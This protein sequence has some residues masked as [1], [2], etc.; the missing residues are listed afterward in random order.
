MKLFTLFTT[1]FLSLNVLVAATY[2]TGFEDASKT[3]YA[4][5][6]VTLSGM[7]WNMTEALIGSDANDFKNDTKSARLRGYST[8][9]ITMQ[10]N[11][12]GGIGEISFQYRRYGTD[13]QVTWRVEYSIDNGTTWTQAGVDFTAPASNDIQT[14]TAT[15]N[16]ASD[17]RI[18]II[19]ASGGASSNRRLNI[20]DIILTDYASCTA[21]SVPSFQANSIQ[22]ETR[23]F[24]LLDLSWTKSSDGQNSL[25]MINTS[26]SFVA[27][28]NGSSPTA[29]TVYGGSGQQVIYSGSANQVSIS[30]LDSGTTYYFVVF[31]YNCSGSNTKFNTSISTN[32]TNNVETLKCPCTPDSYALSPS[33]DGGFQTGTS[34][35]ANGWT[36]ANDGKE[37]DWVLGMNAEGRTTSRTAYISE[38][39]GATHSYDNE[40]GSDITFYRTVDL[41]SFTTSDLVK[42]EF[43]WTGWCNDGVWD[44][45]NVYVNNNKLDANDLHNQMTWTKTIYDI[46]TYA[47]TSVELKFRWVIGTFAGENH[48][49]AVDN[50]A[51]YNLKAINSV[52]LQQTALHLIAKEI[53]NYNQILWKST[54]S[55]NI[56]Y[57]EIQKSNDGKNFETFDKIYTNEKQYE[58]NDYYPDLKT[59]YRIVSVK[60]NGKKTNSNTVFVSRKLEELITI[61]PNPVTTILYLRLKSEKLTTNSKELILYN[62]LGQEVYKTNLTI[63]NGI[64]NYQI[65]IE[66][67][68]NGIYFLKVDGF[69]IYKIVKK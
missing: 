27:P 66:K 53:K 60:N 11:K 2:T 33:G 13:A 29:N 10:G 67:F 24:T 9:S 42:L 20:D 5:G 25:V 26:N 51:I 35:A 50:I 6:D 12:T 48:P 57:Y 32:N 1:A 46:S 38:D 31:A 34:F 8:S 54:N 17:A 68:E 47:G 52:P 45:L 65:N 37:N 40:A 55:G 22:F 64:L 28:T 44:V 62:T 21:D 69:E 41:S 36:V 58:L 18:R 19:H 61:Y 23:G 59:Y 3:A 43:E 56:A 30:G 4:S 16:I 49:H 39:G 63:E 14:F 7:V 15:I